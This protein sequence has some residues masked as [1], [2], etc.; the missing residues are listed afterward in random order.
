MDK[1]KNGDIIEDFYIKGYESFSLVENKYYGGNQEWLNS[2]NFT[3]KFWADRAC[4]VVAAANIL[5]YKADNLNIYSLY[6]YKTRCKEDFTK[7]INDVYMFINPALYGVPT[8]GNMT[9]G[10]LRFG[11]ARGVKFEPVYFKDKWTLE[12]IA[13]YIKAGLRENN[14]IMLLTWN[15]QIKELRNHWVTITRFYRTRDG[16]SYILTSN[17]GRM[18]TYSLDKWFYKYSL[19]KGVIY[20]KIG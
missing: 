11:E 15:T 4:G 17:W 2:H 9:K 8:V 20:F 19:Y 5:A 14:P 12:N 7:H 16:M 18:K 3:T 13:N 10:F 1:V 6:P